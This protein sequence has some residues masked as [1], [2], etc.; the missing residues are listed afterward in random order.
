MRTKP[1]VDLGG[2]QTEASPFLAFLIKLE[3]WVLSAML[4]AMILL[5]CYQIG[6]RW[7]TSG[8]LSWIDPLVRYLV[9]WS[10]MMGAVLATA[11]DQHITL[12]IAGFM[13]S[14]PIQAGLKL[15]AG[16]VSVVVSFFLLVASMRFVAGEREFPISGLLGISTW[17]WNLIFP[18]A[19]AII[20]IHFALNCRLQIRALWR[21]ASIDQ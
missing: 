16:L 2:D 5:A 18:I 13:V 11:R 6:L 20:L 17:I 7:F 1:T 12:D 4:G 14:E 19:F 9:L 10:G 15:L 8:G 3:E 21:G